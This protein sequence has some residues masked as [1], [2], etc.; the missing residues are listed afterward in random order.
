MTKM[1]TAL[2]AL[3]AAVAAMPASAQT[4]DAY[5]D[6]AGTA[7][8]TAS[9]NGRFIYGVANVTTPGTPGSNFDVNTA[10]H[11]PGSTCLQATA[12]GGNTAS[13]PGVYK[14]G[15]SFGSVTVPTDALLIHPGDGDRN[16]VTYTAFVAPTAGFYRLYAT[17]RS[18]D[19]SP[20]G[21]DLYRVGTTSGGLPLTFN[22]L[23]S[24]STAPYT[25]FQ[26]VNLG[27]SEAI[28]YAI[29]N[30]GQFFNDST[31]VSFAVVAGVPEPA[32]W[33]LMIMGFGAIGSALR[34]RARTTVAYA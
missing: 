7:P 25:D 5:R 1:M 12:S 23:T 28:G 18:Q 19:S 6:F 26:L 27:A 10:C 8:Q 31:G 30:G 4:Y 34:R 9:T 15:S 14:G 24:N 13:L 22:Q 33:A 16:N 11:I 32:T 3:T 20:T 29:G 17:F 21:I 2:V